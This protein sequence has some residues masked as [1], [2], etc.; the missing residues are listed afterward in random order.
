MRTPS[1]RPAWSCT[2][3]SLMRR[4]ISNGF[5]PIAHQHNAAD[6]FVAVFFQAGAAHGGAELHAGD[7]RDVDRS[8]ADAFDDDALD[9]GKRLNP[10]HAADQIFRATLLQH[11]TADGGIGLRHGRI[12]LAQRHAVGARAGS[13]RR[14]FDIR[15]ESHRRWPPPPP[16]ARF[17]VDTAQ[18]NL[19]SLAIGPHL[20]HPLRPCTKRSDPGPWHRAPDRV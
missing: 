19:E 12:Q 10:S 20:D 1:G 8:A 7:L 6:R 3:L 5:S 13:D 11:P 14:R 9:V 18:T 2:I 15:S 17:A 16:P 4:V